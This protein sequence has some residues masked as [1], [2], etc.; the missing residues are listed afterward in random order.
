MKKLVLLLFL[1]INL[2]GQN[3]LQSGPMVGYCEMKEAM[4]WLQTKTEAKVKIEYFATDLPSKVF[5]S[6]VYETKKNNAFTAHVVLTELQPSKKYNYSVIIDKKKVSLPFETS[7]SAKKLWLWR[8]DAPD[9]TVALGSCSYI[10]EEAVDRPGKPYGSNYSIFESINKKNPDIMLWGGDYIYLREADWDTETGINHRY[11]HTR[12]IK[13]TQALFA[14]TQ[15]YAIWDDHDFG[16]NDGDR[17]FYMKHKTQEAFKNFW[18]NKTYGIGADQT[19][20][21]FTQFNWGDA[22]FFLLD[23]RFFKSPNDRV[24][25][26]KT[27]LGKQQLDWLIDALINSKASFKAIVIGGQ[28]LN[29]AA[30]YENYENYKDEKELLLKEIAAN[31]IR[32]VFFISGDRHSTELSALK[33]EGTYPLLDWTVSPMTSGP[34]PLD[35]VA[36]EGNTNRVEGSL[37]AEH[38]FGTLSFS[39]KKDTR[40]MKMTLFNKEGVELW[41]KVV[42]KKDL[43]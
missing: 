28:V 27:M 5:T 42:L 11:T 8:E 22:D 20:G 37:F 4:I 10:S 36:K 13:E 41:N 25:G 7:F 18:A 23:N 1:S 29:T 17:S 16:P 31:K 35:K 26:E 40:Q 33:R 43:Q 6:E 21:V 9:F 34:A 30:V 12:S 32:G 38:C 15:N 39:G 2:F 14:K 24:T 3:N 19:Q